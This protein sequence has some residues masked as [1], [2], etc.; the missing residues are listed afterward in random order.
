MVCG[1]DGCGREP[2]VA[3]GLC[4]R[5]YQRAYRNGDVTRRHARRREKTVAAEPRATG[6]RVG[7]TTLAR[8]LSELTPGQR[9]RLGH[10]LLAGG[11]LR[12][13]DV[14]SVRRWQ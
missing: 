10:Q 4:G 2:V 11:D 13:V 1:E 7:G 6:D 5:C 12:E 8:L 9:R 3:R 14:A